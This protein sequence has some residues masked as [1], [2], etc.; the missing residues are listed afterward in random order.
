MGWRKLLED[1][2]VEFSEGLEE[3]E[4]IRMI[5]RVLLWLTLVENV[6]YDD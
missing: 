2:L 5:E 1:Q 4:M 3:R 6:D